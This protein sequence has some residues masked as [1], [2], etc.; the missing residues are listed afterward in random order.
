MGSM[1]REV[2]SFLWMITGLV[3]GLFANRFTTLGH[4]LLHFSPFMIRSMIHLLVGF[5]SQRQP[6]GKHVLCPGNPQNYWL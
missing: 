3:I 2:L 5:D 1:V 4:D 6:L